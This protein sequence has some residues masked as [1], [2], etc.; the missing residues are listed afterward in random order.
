MKF[1]RIC[2]LVCGLM[3]AF[4]GVTYAS[5]FSVSADKY[6]KVEGNG[7]EFSFPENNNTIQIA[8]LTK[9]NERYLIVGKYGE[10][11]YAAKIP[12]VKYVRVK[13][14]YDTETGKYAYI[15]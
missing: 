15:K 14:V 11:I 8:F 12:N 9:D 10:P 3:L 4:V 7:I 2:L 5:S 1:I 13:Q 6:G